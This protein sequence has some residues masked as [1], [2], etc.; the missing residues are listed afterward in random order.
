MKLGLSAIAF[1][2]LVGCGQGGGGVSTTKGLAH[3]GAEAN[4]AVIFGSPH[5]LEG[6]ATDVREFGN[7]L[8]DARYDFHFQDVK[9]NGD[10]TA[11]EVLGMTGDAARNADTLLWFFSGHGNT[12]IMLAN[13]RT[14]TFHEVADAIKA[15]RHDKPLKRLIV[16]IDS[17]FSGSFVD[18]DAPIIEGQNKGLAD[19]TDLQ[20]LVCRKHPRPAD[21]QPSA[22]QLDAVTTKWAQTAVFD[23]LASYDRG[24]FDQAFVM[25]SSTRDES[26]VDLGAEKGGAFTWSL[27]QVMKSL[28][29]SNDKATIQDFAR[30]TSQRTL[31]EG[32]HTPV[33]KGFPAATVMGEEMFHYAN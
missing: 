27:R 13:D 2:L 23:G 18:G 9:S 29:T 28:R 11:D 15:A 32:G 17:C 33:F 31:R 8:E 24:I 21:Q 20:P 25:S 4:A 30:M 12:G 5:N 26:S 3:G 19:S 6:V 7:L 14:F 16:L 1:I 22:A 10:A